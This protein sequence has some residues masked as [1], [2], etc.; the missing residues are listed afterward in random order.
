MAKI[1]RMTQEE[2]DRINRD[3]QG[4]MATGASIDQIA[5]VVDLKPDTVRKRITKIRN[6][7]AEEKLTGEETRDE[8]IA[9][10]NRI[11]MLASAGYTRVKEKSANGE[12]TFLKLQL[13]VLDRIAKLSGVYVPDR[14][15]VSGKNGG[16]IQIQNAEHPLDNISAN[17]LAKRMRNWAEALEEEADGK[18]AVPAVV[19][20]TSE[21]V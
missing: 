16:P 11:S 10:A 5:K 8:L 17:D 13:E 9:R 4:L 19:E 1:G 21:N 14:V 12:A 15:E 3:I 6:S 7:W 18:P 20:G 2:N